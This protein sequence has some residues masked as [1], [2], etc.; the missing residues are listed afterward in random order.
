LC[1]QRSVSG[2]ELKSSSS[3]ML[4]LSLNILERRLGR[5]GLLLDCC[6]PEFAGLVDSEYRCLRPKRAVLLI[7][8]RKQQ[9]FV[10]P[11]MSGCR[12]ACCGGRGRAGRW[13][14]NFVSRMEGGR[15]TRGLF[16][17]LRAVFAACLRGWCVD[18]VGP[19]ARAGV[20][21]AARTRMFRKV[22]SAVCCR[23]R[24]SLHQISRW[25]CREL[26]RATLGGGFCRC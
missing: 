5:C 6:W 19:T 20:C 2:K 10:R 26:S 16:G 23:R 13:C 12:H 7:S 18:L 17:Q 24:L 1:T 22:M 25:Q 4:G 8:L 11:F 21:Y 15:H 3:A 9:G 14:P